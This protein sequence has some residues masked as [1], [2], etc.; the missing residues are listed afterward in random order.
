MLTT[1]YYIPGYSLNFFS[2]KDYP[3]IVLPEI[4]SLVNI[5]IKLG[6]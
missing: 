3:L 5:V 6:A 4:S 2:I 1:T